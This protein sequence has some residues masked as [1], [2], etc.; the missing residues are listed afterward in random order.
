MKDF[1]KNVILNCLLLGSVWVA[2]FRP[3]SATELIQDPLGCKLLNSAMKDDGL[4]LLYECRGKASK[5]KSFLL[6]SHLE[7]EGF[8][9]VTFEHKKY[10]VNSFVFG[11][12]QLIG[13]KGMVDA[14]VPGEG[15]ESVS[16]KKILGAW[17]RDQSTKKMTVVPTSR[18]S[19]C[20]E[21]AG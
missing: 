8:D 12:C 5:R 21:P 4:Y 20:Y 2:F 3:A 13:E 11:Y 9:D 14:I 1:R 16:P 10:E 18:L 6:R 19:I 7:G 17:Q 15:R